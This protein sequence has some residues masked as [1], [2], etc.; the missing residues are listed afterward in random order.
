MPYT[1]AVKVSKAALAAAAASSDVPKGKVW[2]T[3]KAPKNKKFTG[4]KLMRK[5]KK[6][7]SIKA[8]RWNQSM[9][10]KANQVIDGKTAEELLAAFE[11][12]MGKH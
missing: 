9:K 2:K 4:T 6:V 12:M 1:R 3:P 5:C 8:E 7:F 10:V 11:R